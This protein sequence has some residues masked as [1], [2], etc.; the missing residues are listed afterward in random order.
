MV[1]DLGISAMEELMMVAQLR[2]PLWVPSM[3][4]Y[5]FEL[6][7]EEYLRVFSR[8]FRQKMNGFKFEASRESVVVPTCAANVVNI[9]MDVEQWE[10]VFSGVVSRAVNFQVISYGLGGTYN[11]AVLVIN[12]EFQNAKYHKHLVHRGREER[13]YLWFDPSKEQ[14]TS[15][16]G[17]GDSWSRTTSF[18][19]FPPWFL[20][21]PAK[22]D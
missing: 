15:F 13:Y 8:V 21:F 11:E 12:A 5:S 7:E 17:S 2:E 19:G 1:V 4:R 10:N 3:D 20:G 16:L 9:L 22:W 6:N 14:T 18:L